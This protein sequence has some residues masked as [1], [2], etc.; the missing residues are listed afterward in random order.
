[1]IG[2]HVHPLP[3][4]VDQLADAPRDAIDVLFE[5]VDESEFSMV[6]GGDVE[7]APDPASTTSNSVIM[8]C[9]KWGGPMFAA[10]PVVSPVASVV[11]AASE[12]SLVASPGGS[13]S[14]IDRS[15]VP[16]G[17]KQSMP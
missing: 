6:D 1:M 16:T 11:V 9:V 3:P 5:V 8:P 4:R 17:M 2:H 10:S 7:P 13:P 12:V 14:N 15:V